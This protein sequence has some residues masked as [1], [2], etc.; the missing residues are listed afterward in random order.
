VRYISV[1][2]GSAALGLLF[3]GIGQAASIT[4]WNTANVEIGPAGV[5]GASTVYDRDVTGGTAGAVTNG[6]I[7]YDFPEA[8]SPGIKVV[9]G[10]FS[11]GGN[12]TVGC[13]MAS[14]TATCDSGFQSGKRFK[15]QFTGTGPVDLVFDVDPTTDPTGSEGYQVFQKLINQTGL[16]MTGFEI[17]LGTGI[18]DG[19]VVSTVGDGLGFSPS[20]EFGPTDANASSQFPFGLF[21]D[22]ADNPNFS[23]DGFFAPE[24]SGF[25]VGFGEDVLAT[26]GF[27]GPYPG[28]FGAG[29]L[30][31]EAVPMGAFWDDD[32]DPTTD[33]VLIAWL[34]GDGEWE[35]RREIVGGTDVDT[36]AVPET[37]A[38]FD[39]LV[40]AIGLALVQGEIED[41]ANVNVNFAV[42]VAAFTGNS[43]TLRVDGSFDPLP[44][45]DSVVPL[46]ATLPLLLSAFGLIGVASM[47]RH[48]AV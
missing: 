45:P 25:N 42:D 17:S 44:A 9:Q 8:D 23:I 14:S 21:G 27:F 33:D 32:N 15:Q 48:R 1:L 7:A 4:G 10:P 43:F 3:S 36:L 30:S 47:R 29:M 6:R 26:S 28:L 35:Q 18:G 20:F 22:A 31:Q 38:T 24:R 16:A 13:I 37:Y 40:S 46:P 19:F 39:E 41:L 11:Q 12:A 5:S 34:N 2:S